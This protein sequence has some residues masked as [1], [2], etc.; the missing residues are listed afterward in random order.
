MTRETVTSENR[1]AFIAKKMGKKTEKK[2]N[3][4]E[5]PFPFYKK[6]DIVKTH[7]SHIKIHEHDEKNKGYMGVHTSPYGEDVKEY[8][9][10]EGG[11]GVLHHEIGSHHQLYARAGEYP[12]KD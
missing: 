10:K 3:K 9:S 7:H 4:P 2:E 11:V 5:I 1:E 12:K 8:N 6:G